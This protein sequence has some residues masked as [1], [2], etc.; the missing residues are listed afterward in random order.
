MFI[1]QVL[2]LCNNLLDMIIF[3]SLFHLK[4]SLKSVKI[5]IKKAFKN[6]TDLVKHFLYFIYLR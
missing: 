2:I 3:N 6:S 5:F 4:F 1:N